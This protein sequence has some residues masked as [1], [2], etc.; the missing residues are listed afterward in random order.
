MSRIIAEIFWK[1]SSQKMMHIVVKRF[2]TM[3]NLSH[4]NLR[5]FGEL[6]ST[7]KHAETAG[8]G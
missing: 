1:N 6:R 7:D 2:L 5:F 3:G 8:K 4:G